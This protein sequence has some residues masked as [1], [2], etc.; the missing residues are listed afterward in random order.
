MQDSFYTR[1]FTPITS[2]FNYRYNGSGRAAIRTRSVEFT[3]GFSLVPQE[4]YLQLQQPQ[5]RAQKSTAQESC[6]ATRLAETRIIVSYHS[7][8]QMDPFPGGRIF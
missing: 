2:G 1:P 3:M 5:G 7:K 4:L 6:R 8:G